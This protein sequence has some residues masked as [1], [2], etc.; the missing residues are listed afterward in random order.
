MNINEI[1]VYSQITK[2]NLLTF[3][4][5][6]FKTINNRKFLTNWHHELICKELEEVAQYKYTFL[7]INIPP[8]FSK[9]ELAA[10]NF[11]SWGLANN[12]QG[13][14]LYITASDNLRK[15]VSVRIRSIISHELYK[16][17]Y[18]VEMSK[19]MSSNNLW[20]TTVGGGLMTAT[21][22]GQI[23]GF[24]AG[25]M[26]DES[27]DLI[28]VINNF[29]GCIVLDD[30]NKIIDAS[31]N[32][33][34]NK[35]ANEVILNTIQ[36]RKN[37]KKTPVINIQQRAG[38]DDATATL[39]DF[40]K[41]TENVKNIILPIYNDNNE[42]LWENKFGWNEINQLKSNPET[43]YIFETQ[44]L[45]QPTTKESRLF[46]IENLQFFNI[47]DIDLTKATFLS[48]S[49]PSDGGDYFASIFV[50][51]INNNAYIVDVLF[52]KDKPVINLEKIANKILQYKIL[53]NTIEINKGGSLLVETLYNYLKSDIYQV[54]GV[55]ETINKE[56]RINVYSDYICKKVYFL[57]NY[58]EIPEY[59][60]FIE[61]L[62]TYSNNNK[63]SHD[64]AP[65]V[66]A[67]LAKHMFN[68]LEI[69][70]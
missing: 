32:S 61:N 57:D 58:K 15:D 21:I 26:Q 28:D 59:K 49:D 63:N 65:D 38:L 17:M 13:N 46:E 9:T 43:R 29:D 4:Q 50:A 48:F 42:L 23:T 69:N 27:I 11:I 16:K 2:A 41:D 64:D 68:I 39:L 54:F 56:Y 30:I 60:Q 22:F 37:S 47:K 5:F 53:D 35:K 1:N 51:I 10:I 3:V 20:K 34:N 14:Y 7:N 6:W 31:T 45:Q 12:P 25:L 62:T 55:N 19:T 67:A 24:G 44:Y 36:S 33:Q 70:L 52:N 40:N 66:L 8:R 18:G